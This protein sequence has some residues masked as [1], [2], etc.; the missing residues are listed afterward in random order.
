MQKEQEDKPILSWETVNT[1]RDK[2]GLLSSEYIAERAKVPRRVAG[3]LPI[4]SWSRP[5]PC[6]RSR[7]K[8]PM[9]RWEPSISPL[10]NHERVAF[11]RCRIRS[12]CRR[13]GTT[14]ADVGTRYNSFE[15]T[16][17]KSVDYTNGIFDRVFR[18]WFSTRMILKPASL[19]CR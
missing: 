4:Q 11:C 15:V 10:I 16:T 7:P 17:V 18:W 13:S 2:K 5:R 8:S 12:M 6:L 1:T 9:G 14:A 19:P 3:D